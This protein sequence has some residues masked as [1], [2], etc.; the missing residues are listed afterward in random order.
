MIK[1]V[2]QLIIHYILERPKKCNRELNVKY[3][4]DKC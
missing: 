4:F 2:A 1:I 3:L